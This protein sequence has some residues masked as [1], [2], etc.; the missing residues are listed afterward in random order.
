VRRSKAS[1]PAPSSSRS[2]RPP[3]YEAQ[4]VCRVGDLTLE[5]VGGSWI[6]TGTDDQADDTVIC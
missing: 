6:V 3:G 5:K 4:E 2:S 1:L